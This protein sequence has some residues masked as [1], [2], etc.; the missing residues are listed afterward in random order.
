M[1]CYTGIGSRQ[2]PSEILNEFSSIAIRLA[3]A[4]YILRSGGAD[5]AD[6]A[7]E[8]GVDTF[9]C[10]SGEPITS[11][12]ALKEIYL[13]WKGFNSSNSDLFGVS[14]KTLEMAG[15]IHPAFHRCSRGGKLLHGR[16]IYQVLG[17]DLKSPSD[18]VIAYAETQN[19]EPKGGT[20]TA[21]MLARQWNIPVYNFYLEAD[22]GSWREYESTIR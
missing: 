14:P 5:G 6:L 19:G 2:T 18:F 13:P 3:R 7:F 20:R 10:T 16:N 11:I 4:G 15:K 1:K 8:S 17:M 9:R 21:I 22:R 12:K